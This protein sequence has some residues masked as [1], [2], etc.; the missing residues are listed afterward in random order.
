MLLE[1]FSNKNPYSE[2]DEVPYEMVK[3][4]EGD[5]LKFTLIALKVRTLCAVGAS[6]DGIPAYLHYCIHLQVIVSPIVQ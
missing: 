1:S 3:T 5:Y 4:D 2:M 6:W